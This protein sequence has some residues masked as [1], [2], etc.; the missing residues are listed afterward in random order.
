MR[1]FVGGEFFVPRLLGFFAVFTCVPGFVDLFRD[2]KRRVFPAQFLT[3]QRHFFFT[4]RCAVRLFFTRFI[5]RAKTNRGAA[6]NQR[7]FIGDALRF[8]NCLL[9]CLRIVAVNFMHDVPVIGLEAFRRVVGKPAIGFTVD[10]NAVVIVEP[11]QF[12]QPQR[13]GQRAD[14]VRNPLH[15]TA[16][17]HENVGEVIDDVMARLVELCGKGALGDRQ[18]DGVCQPLTEWSG[19][20]FDAR[21]IAKLRVSRG[22]GMQLAEIFDLGQRQIVAG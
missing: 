15:Q 11:D 7:W 10:G 16:I 9:N 8:F 12:A 6:D 1:F 5:W 17:A 20:G 2:L 21:R 22:F 3:R 13:T 19:R 18:P 4:Q 14:F